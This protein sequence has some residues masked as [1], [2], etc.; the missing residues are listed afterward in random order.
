MKFRAV[1]SDHRILLDLCES[2]QSVQKHLLVKLSE[3]KVRLVTIDGGIDTDDHSTDARPHVWASIPTTALF[4]AVVVLSKRSNEIFCLLKTADLAAALRQGGLSLS[5]APLSPQHLSVKLSKDG[6]QPVLVFTSSTEEE[7]A[8]SKV[9]H[10]VPVQ[11]IGDEGP[12]LARFPDLVNGVVNLEMPSLDI[13]TTFCVSCQQLSESAMQALCNT[14]RGSATVIMKIDAPG[15]QDS[16]HRQL[17]LFSAQDT[18]CAKCVFAAVPV[19]TDI[20]QS[21]E[22]ASPRDTALFISM[23]PDRLLSVLRAIGRVRQ[24]QNGEKAIHCTAQNG[25]LFSLRMPSDI[26]VLYHVP[27]I[28]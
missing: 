12:E 15:S 10:F 23:R 16:K 26:A 4:S 8:L 6:I 2:I 11:V 21:T 17:S 25:A 22:A 27:C 24:A 19:L 20:A 3:S 1:F 5:G 14:Q 18:A 28:P 9:N 7:T 13:L